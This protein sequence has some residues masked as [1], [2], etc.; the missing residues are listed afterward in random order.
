[1]TLVTRDDSRMV[2]DIEKLIKKKIEIE[3]IE[4]EDDR[5]RPP[6]RA[7]DEDDSYR[8]AARAIERA[9]DRSTD[10]TSERPRRPSAPPSD[11]FFDKPYEPSGTGSASWERGPAPAAPAKTSVSPNIRPKKKVGSLLGG[12]S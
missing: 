12:G 7:R 1:V 9:S 10:R 5:R 8:E 4:I 6:P 3:P 11:P 2:S